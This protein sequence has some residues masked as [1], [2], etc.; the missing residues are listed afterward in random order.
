[1]VILGPAAASC[2]ASCGI[3]L[4]QLRVT[5]ARKPACLPAC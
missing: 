5:Q 2:F 4:L 3:V 1:V